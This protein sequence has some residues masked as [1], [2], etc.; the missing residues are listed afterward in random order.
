MSSA[1]FQPLLHDP[2][3]WKPPTTTY[4]DT[5]KNRTYGTSS[6]TQ[7][8][9]S[10]YGQEYQ[11][12]LRKQQ[13]QM[14]LFRKNPY[15]VQSFSDEQSTPRIIFLEKNNEEYREQPPAAYQLTRSKTLPAFSEEKPTFAAEC[16]KP[17]YREP[18]Y[19]STS[20]QRL[21]SAQFDQ[22]GPMKVRR[23]PKEDKEKHMI[24]INDDQYRHWLTYPTPDTP[25]QVADAKQR[26]GQYKIPQTLSRGTSAS[27]AYAEQQ[28]SSSNDQ[29]GSNVP[30][31]R[32]KQVNDRGHF[33][34]F[35]IP[36]TP[37][38]LRAARHRLEKHRY[39]QSLDNYPPHLEVNPDNEQEEYV[40]PSD[41]PQYDEEQA[42]QNQPPSTNEESGDAGDENRAADYEQ[43]TLI[44]QTNNNEDLPEEYIEA[45][46]ISDAAQEEYYKNCKPY[47]EKRS[48]QSYY[49][50][51]PISSDRQHDSTVAYCNQQSTPSTNSRNA[52]EFGV[53]I[54]NSSDQ[55]RESAMKILNNVLKQPMVGYGVPKKQ[56]I[57]FKRPAGC[58]I[59]R[60][61]SA[62]RQ[63]GHARNHQ[64]VPCEICE[65][66]L[67]KH[68]IWSLS[69]SKTL[70][71]PH[72]E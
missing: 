39:H 20:V 48:D 1:L 65:K 25:P 34:E 41:A 58:N 37:P 69:R 63:L 68:H 53:W 45:L 18:N 64:R 61:A 26:L 44:E 72:Q 54:R 42:S 52:N 55:E 6:N 49:R 47:C 70:A 4:S 67:I 27:Y 12:Q 2:L 60:S 62:S 11:K 22:R 9:L 46:D 29:S 23:N 14:K 17:A 38:E 28:P 71:C 3:G 10:P 16:Q 51:P 43:S 15:F 31:R 8:K 50:I 59:G 21:P 35:N 32:K 66:Q 24:D 33:L 36:P 7:K 30:H 13:Q 40:K 57:I 19:D 5:F 56:Q